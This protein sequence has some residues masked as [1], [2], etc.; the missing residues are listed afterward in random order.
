M[1]RTINGFQFVA[2]EV[3]AG[4]SFVMLPRVETS[5]IRSSLGWQNGLRTI[6]KGWIES[7]EIAI[8]RIAKI[9]LR[10]LLLVQD[11]FLGCSHALQL[12]AGFAPGVN[13]SGSL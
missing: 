7:E 9:N 1:F 11:T 4:K 10:P 3:D 8:E 2:N 13:L 5:R 12:V 6:Q